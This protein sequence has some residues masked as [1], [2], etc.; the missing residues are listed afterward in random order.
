MP[1][2]GLGTE[3]AVCC[4]DCKAPSG[5]VHDWWRLWSHLPRAEP[6]LISAVKH[7]FGT[8]NQPEWFISGGHTL[9][10]SF[11][12]D[13][14]SLY[15]YFNSLHINSYPSSPAI[16]LIR[17]LRP[18]AASL[19]QITLIGLTLGSQVIKVTVCVHLPGFV[20]PEM[21][22]MSS[23]RPAHR[24]DAQLLPMA[25]DLMNSPSISTHR[26]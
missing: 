1:I 13:E 8:I 16:R 21:A 14:T 12:E 23:T 10:F 4:S 20:F 26:V 22:T 2:K 25:S 24:L 19:Q 6:P 17:A 7:L 15:S 3:D 5:K 9:E 18:I 11:L